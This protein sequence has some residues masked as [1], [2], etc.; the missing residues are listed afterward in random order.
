LRELI[1]SVKTIG[2]LVN[3]A[4]IGN[5]LQRQDIEAAAGAHAIHIV[6]AEIRVPDDL[7][8]AFTLL[9]GEHVPVFIAL[10]DSLTTAQPDRV[11]KLAAQAR[12][13]GIYG[14]RE[15]VEAGGL[16]SYGINLMAN[17]HRIAAL[18]DKILKGEQVANIPVEFPT[19]IELLI[20]L[21]TA[22]ALGLE[23][24]PTLLA[25]ADEVIE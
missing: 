14:F 22:K 21:K 18:V 3:V 11:V 23:I 13:P 4:N 12:L 10:R 2:L 1:P 5:K 16:I 8:G 25:R 15:F 6:A 7:D 9:A 24:P 20:N 19:K 17:W